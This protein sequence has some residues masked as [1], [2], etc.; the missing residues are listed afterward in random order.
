MIITKCILYFCLILFFALCYLLLG[1]LG[2]GLGG[3]GV[4]GAL[5][6]GL[7]DTDG[8]GLAHITDGEAA[9]GRV[10][11]EGLNAE[12]LGGD[13]ADHGGVAHL[14]GLGFLLEFLTGTAVD[15]GFDLGELAGDVGGVAVEDGGVAVADLTGVVEDDD[16]GE[17]VL[18]LLGGVVLGVGADVA[19]ADVLDGQVLDVEADVVAG[20]GLGDG[21]VV[22]LNK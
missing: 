7:D 11:S 10:L 13:K 9:E 18:G 8:D 20:D 6:D 14:D 22:H 3:L 4:S 21:L 12:G 17:E 2:S 1:S 15:L 5:G 16:L 19:T